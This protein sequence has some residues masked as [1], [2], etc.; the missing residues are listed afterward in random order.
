MTPDHAIAQAARLLEF[1]EAE[2]DLAKMERWEHLA[3]SWVNIAALLAEH[4][5]A[6]GPS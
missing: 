1:A 2:T 5:D 4:V 6:R 3:D